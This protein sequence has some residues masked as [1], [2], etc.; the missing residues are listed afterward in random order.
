MTEKVCFDI[1]HVAKNGRKL[2]SGHAEN[3]IFKSL[4]SLLS[5][6]VECRSI[7]ISLS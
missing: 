2:A 4:T 5:S 6:M 3:I 7:F 1:K